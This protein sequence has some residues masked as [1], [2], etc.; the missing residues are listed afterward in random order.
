MPQSMLAFMAMM[1]ATLAALNQYRAQLDTY[2]ELILSE[3]EIMA[4]A[5]AIEQM[6]LLDIGTDWED[7]EDVDGDTTQ[8]SFSASDLSVDFD[9]IFAVQFVD[10]DG[11]PSPS[12]TSIKEVEIKAYN[13]KFTLPM[14]THTRLFSE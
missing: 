1:L 13:E 7:L 9:L 12:P 6:E 10:E 2:E 11:D 8:V 4:N 14:V 5:V 3:Y